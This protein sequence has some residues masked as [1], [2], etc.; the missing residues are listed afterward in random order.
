[1]PM[2]KKYLIGVDLG[3]SATKAAIYTLN[4]KLVAVASVEVPIYYPKPGVVEQVNEDFYKS[5]A[6][7]VQTAI[8][9]SG[10][11]PKQVPAIAFDSQ[12]AGVG[13]I[14]EDFEPVTRFDSWLDMCCE[15]YIKQ[16]EDSMGELI[17]RLDRLPTHLRLRPK[18]PA[19][20]A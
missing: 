3:T 16:L 6:V 15:P 8:R 11:D 9:E 7:T 12:M 2:D 1:M 5:A 18:D 17:T 4:G 20:E 14:D 19:Y 13:A 10:I